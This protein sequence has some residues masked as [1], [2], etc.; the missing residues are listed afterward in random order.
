MTASA[1]RE[2]RWLPLVLVSLALPPVTV[3]GTILF[4]AMPVLIHELGAT[5]SQV[6]WIVDIYPL[7]MTGLVLASGPLGDRF[8]QRTTLC[9]GLLVFGLASIACAYASDPQWLVV[10]RGLLAVGG[11]LIIPSS[12]AIVRQSFA[13]PRERAVAIGV[14][15]AVSA[16]GAALG[17]VAGGLLLEHFWWGSVFLVNVPLAAAVLALTLWLLPAAA[18]RGLARLPVLSPLLGVVGV[19]ALVYAL[20][21]LAH[22][23]AAIEL[24]GSLA[25]GVPVL[26]LFVLR[27]RRAAE[28]VFDFGLFADPR[29]R[30]G[31]AAALLPMSVLVGVDLLLSQQLQFVLGMTPLEAGL[32]LL[33]ASLAAFVAAPLGGLL[34]GRHGMRRVAVVALLVAA[35][36]Y[37]LIGLFLPQG[38]LMPVLLALGLT[39]LGHGVV[40]T[41]A[42][43]AVM[44]SAPDTA[45]G[46]AAAIESVSYEMGAGFGIAGFGSLMAFLYTAGLPALAPA[47]VGHSVGEALRLAE[48]LPAQAGEPLA[49]AA[50]D[51]YAAAF[52]DVTLVGAALMA[53]FALL[54][55]YALR[56][57]KP[58]PTS[59]LRAAPP[60]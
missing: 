8:G 31:V 5:G 28:P 48:T 27:E 50:R 3:D 17:P 47:G 7:L 4:V 2:R 13:D 25:L 36:G 1:P 53:L 14:W 20:K 42:S 40:M 11:A 16:G 45:A 37:L 51:A 34:L 49:N 55:G 57:R 29:F 24:L 10:G 30:V 18:R 19:V 33:P 9:A 43:D 44:S 6:L 38:D 39:G 15:G 46:R 12:L 52:H 41:A 59:A 22:G 58:H 26:A 35:L 21:T 54:V 32:I 56:E 23:G 60:S